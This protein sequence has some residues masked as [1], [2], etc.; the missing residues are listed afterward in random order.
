MICYGPPQNL[1][2]KYF[3]QAS[4]FGD[5]VPDLEYIPQ[6]SR[7]ADCGRLGRQQTPEQ[8][9]RCLHRLAAPY[10]RG[11]SFMMD[12]FCNFCPSPHP[13]KSNAVLGSSTAEVPDLRVMK[14]IGF[15]LCALSAATQLQGGVTP[16]QKVPRPL[17]DRNPGEF[18]RHRLV[19]MRRACNL[20][21]LHCTIDCQ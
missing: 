5:R 10:T 8:C 12:S 21:S 14:M 13:Q 9:R 2:T 1:P 17:P 3:Q 4:A 11:W 16:V 7:V 6:R 15:V 19:G 20:L 18:A